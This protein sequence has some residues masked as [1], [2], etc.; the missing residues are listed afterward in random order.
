MLK[1]RSVKHYGYEFLYGSNSVDPEHPL[2]GGLPA[3]CTALLERILE[4]GLV[5]HPPD[6]LTVNQYLPGSGQWMVCV[7]V[8]VWF[9]VSVFPGI[10]PHVD[11]HSAFEDGII[12]IALGSHVCL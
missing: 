3:I 8:I 2:P 9:H 7:S 12:S 6:Q 1:H 10:P 4:A 5:A 11:T